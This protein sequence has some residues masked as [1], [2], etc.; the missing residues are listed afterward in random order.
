M[1]DSPAQPNLKSLISQPSL[2]CSTNS[3]S[4]PSAKLSP[5]LVI[6]DLK[7]NFEQLQ[8]LTTIRSHFQHSPNQIPTKHGHTELMLGRLKCTSRTNKPRTS[9]HFQGNR[10][11]FFFWFGNCKC[12]IFLHE[13]LDQQME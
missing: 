11:S 5:R 3:Q 4:L 7:L 8:H 13:T 10:E 1:T 2:N 9:I 12:K 6:V